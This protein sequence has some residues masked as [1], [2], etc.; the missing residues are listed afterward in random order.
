MISIK[1]T[2]AFLI[3]TESEKLELIQEVTK[4]I[5]K[6]LIA[7]ANTKGGVIYIGVDNKGHVIGIEDT[8]RVISQLNHMARD[9]IKPDITMF[10]NY[11]VIAVENKNIIA[12]TIQRGTARPYYLR[13]KGLKSSGVY[14]RSGTSADPASDA[15]I[16]KMIKET[17]GDCYE[18]MRSLEQELTFSALNEQLS[19]RNVPL[20]EKKMQTLGLISPDGV[21]SNLAWILSDQSVHTVKAATFKGT[22]KDIFQDRR[23]FSGSLFRQ[24]EEV[25]AYLDL[26]NNTSA[27]FDGLYRTDK[28]DYPE[29]AIR[30]ALLNALVHRD[31]SYSADTLIG[32]YDDRMEF[33]SIG[34]LTGD[35]NLEDI[36]LGLSVCR[37]SK[38]AGIFY[39]LELIEAYGTGIPKIMHAYAGAG[40]TPKIEVTAN[41]FKITLPNRNHLRVRNDYAFHVSENRE[42]YILHFI[43]QR[44]YIV[45]SEADDLLHVSQATSN[46]ILKKMINK[47]I[48][49]QDGNGPETKYRRR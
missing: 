15:L 5:C 49:Y 25:Y 4:D 41:A 31:Y 46:R 40:L 39:R 14:V 17:D 23:E 16:R 6:E 35:L 44:G 1:I 24:M 3:F 26:R 10:I 2:E 20:D 36:M 11:N 38:L 21:Y 19:K 34:G 27:S 42:E 45:R 43:D 30:E 28:R 13:E 37:N 22:D 9:T 29:E 47:G 48:I 7:F 12:V 8:D 33:I 32:V 18:T